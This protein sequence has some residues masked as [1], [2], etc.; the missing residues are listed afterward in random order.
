MNRW[1]FG[2]YCDNHM[3]AMS[4]ANLFPFLDSNSTIK[5]FFV[6]PGMTK[7]ELGRHLPMYSSVIGRYTT[8]PFIDL[9]LK[10]PRQGAYTV[11]YCAVRPDLEPKP[12]HYF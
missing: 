7:T 12:Q 5:Q 4:F 1:Q 9:L 3:F 10:T 11:T 2:R 6:Y 8:A